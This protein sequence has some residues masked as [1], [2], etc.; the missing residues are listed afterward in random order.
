MVLTAVAV[1]LLTGCG[2]GSDAGVVTVTTKVPA[3]LIDRP[4]GIGAT[5]DPSTRQPSITPQPSTP[6]T[7][8]VRSPAGARL[9]PSTP[10]SA[11][12][13]PTVSAG[14]S[15]AASKAGTSPA[16]TPKSGK[17]STGPTAPIRLLPASQIPTAN[18]APV[19]P[20]TPGPQTGPKCATNAAYVDEQPT[21]LRSDVIRAWRNV[22]KYANADDIIVCL[23]DGKRSRAQ[24]Q[25]Q[26]DQYLKQYGKQAADQLVLKPDKS[27][28]VTGIAIDV[29][30]AAAFHWLQATRGALG[31][32][33]TF[34]N[35]G[36]HFEY[37]VSYF[38]G[39]PPRKPRPEH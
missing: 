30:P 11:V 21:G 23:N 32:C 28:H 7:K 17:P 18:A 29:Q 5:G 1:V 34:D 2:S 15:S 19:S 27:A 31:L 3:S 12:S 26:Y 20:E 22:E 35:E 10:S 24:Q 36:W 39:C 38:K 13:A 14:R 6:A 4:S 16:R 9:K 25:A 8:S 33:R 37:D